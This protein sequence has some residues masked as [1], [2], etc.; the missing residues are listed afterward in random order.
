MRSIREATTLERDDKNDLQ[1]CAMTGER[2]NADAS[3]LADELLQIPEEIL[4]L[5]I[6]ELKSFD[7]DEDE[8]E[9]SVHFYIGKHAHRA[10][11]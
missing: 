5:N 11:Q 9:L 4:F 7:I 8:C 3:N 10:T 6:D 1:V 2:T